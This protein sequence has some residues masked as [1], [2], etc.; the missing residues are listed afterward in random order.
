MNDA[1]RIPFRFLCV[2]GEKLVIKW[3]WC[4]QRGDFTYEN[5][6]PTT[7]SVEIVIKYNGFY[8]FITEF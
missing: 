5:T 7:F 6:R 3:T 4:I 2:A 1:Y 8:N